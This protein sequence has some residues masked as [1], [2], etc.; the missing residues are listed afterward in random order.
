MASTYFTL[1]DNRS[2]TEEKSTREKMNKRNGRKKEVL[3]F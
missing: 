2:M 1:F 3:Y